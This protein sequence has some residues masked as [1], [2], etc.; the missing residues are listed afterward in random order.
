MATYT[1]R[2]CDYVKNVTQG[3]DDF[4]R[5]KNACPILF[6]F[7][8]PFYSDDLS[9]KR[10]FESQFIM[11]FY[12]DEIGFETIG[13]FK[14]KLC[15]VLTLNM[16][17]Y[18]KLYETQKE[19]EN[20]FINEDMTYNSESTGEIDSQGLT[21]DTPQINFANVDYANGLT[22]ESNKQKAKSTTKSIGFRGSKL[23]EFDK[24]KKV[25]VNVNKQIINDCNKLFMGI[26]SN[27]G[28]TFNDNRLLG[29]DLPNV[30]LIDIFR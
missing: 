15:E 1:I 18:R 14:L 7:N 28:F 4:E 25:Y 26:N 11:H 8:Y 30:N 10:K 29:F 5:I 24:L 13:L 21:S 27:G 20:I 22:R 17:E 19:I 16:N 2:L 9:V 23:D 12:M 3:G 6:S